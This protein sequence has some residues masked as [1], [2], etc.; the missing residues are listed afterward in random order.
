M[1]VNWQKEAIEDLRRYPALRQ[2]LTAIREKQAALDLQAGVVR[3]SFRDSAPV[4][5]S[6]TSGAEDRLISNIVERERLDGNYA[7]VQKLVAQI[8]TALGLLNKTERLVLER[9]F[10]HRMDGH[11]DRLCQ[12]LGYEK[13]RVYEIKDAALRLFTV[14]MYG[15]L[16]L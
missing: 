10:I 9:F 14:A 8:E 1:V 11:V 6:G 13:T 15:L 5:G 4:S 12:E 16:D 7:A 2:S 3:S